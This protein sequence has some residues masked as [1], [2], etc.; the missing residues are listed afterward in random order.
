MFLAIDIGN[1][2]TVFGLYQ[3]NVLISEI[4]LQSDTT[5]SAQCIQEKILSAF[6]QHQ[7]PTNEIKG[8]GV[9]SVVPSL[10]SLYSEFCQQHLSLNAL[11][12]TSELDLGMQ[13]HYDQPQSLGVD[14]ICSA[15][16]GYA[17][18]GGPLIIVDMGTATTFN[19]IA[20]NGDFLGGLITAGIGTMAASLH[21]RT[22]QL[23]QI[24]FTFPSKIINTNT[25]A[26]IQ[27]GVLIGSREMIEG[28]I[29]NIKS[30]MLQYEKKAP[31]V[32]ATGGFSNLLTQQFP[33]IQHREPTLV[34]DGIRLLWERRGRA[35][36]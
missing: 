4:R 23:P 33:V 6:E 7:V 17:K 11:V 31:I 2:H 3:G 9:S 8:V 24:D 1:S 16:A 21:A 36:N 26:A 12:I 25:A 22:A 28:L 27:A 14:R 18:Y 5:A 30:E 29:R 35:S 10:T 13:L 19:V 32:I 34:L 15:V 20:S